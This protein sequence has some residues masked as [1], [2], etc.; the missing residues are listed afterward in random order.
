[1]INLY[2]LPDDEITP[3]ILYLPTCYTESMPKTPKSPDELQ[4]EEKERVLDGGK[5]Q[6]NRSLS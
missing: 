4:E 6:P 1:M 2:G 5:D 3:P